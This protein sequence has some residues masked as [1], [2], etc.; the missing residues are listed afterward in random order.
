MVY[1][2]QPSE[3]KEHRLSCVSVYVSPNHLS[4]SY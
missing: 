4:Q 3:I 2:I 1:E